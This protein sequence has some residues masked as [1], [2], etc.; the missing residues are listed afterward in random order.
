MTVFPPSTLPGFPDA[1][2]AKRKTTFRGGLRARWKDD[3]AIYEWDY[4]HGHVEVYDA[5]GNHRGAYDAD[6]GQMVSGADSTRRI[7]P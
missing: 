3:N 7:E 1:T 2:R 6:T 5:R 4:Q